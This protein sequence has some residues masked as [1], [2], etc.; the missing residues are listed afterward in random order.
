MS[1]LAETFKVEVL[2]RLQAAPLTD[3]GPNAPLID[4]I[5]RSHLTIV[6]RERAPA[7]HARFGD[8]KRTDDDRAC[9][10]K[11]QIDFKVS[12]YVASDNDAD[13]DPIVVEVIK[14]L[15]PM[16]GTPYANGVDLRLSR[17]ES[18]VEIAD[19]DAQ[20]VD[21]VGSAKF[22]TDPWQIDARAT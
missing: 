15:D 5:R 21:V 19:Q 7:I 16:I 17:V 8:A 1:S 6:D 11:W 10:W 18:D 3:Y 22:I 14:R 9:P 13:A 2:A 12:V 20:R 4:N